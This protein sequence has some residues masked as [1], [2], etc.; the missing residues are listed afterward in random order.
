MFEPTDDAVQ[1]FGQ[2]DEVLYR[3][4]K[5][6]PTKENLSKVVKSL[7]PII[8]REVNRQAGSIPTSVLRGVGMEWAVKAVQSF[9]ESKGFKLSTHTANY[10]KK[11]R[12]SNYQMQNA[13]R[14]PEPL[15]NQYHH[16]STAVD[17]LKVELDRDPTDVELASKLG[18]KKV[19]VT[20]F[21]DRLYQDTFES[22]ALK[23][24][25]VTGFS[26]TTVLLN[27]VRDSL[28]P[29]EQIIFDNQM[30]DK[31]KQLS[32]DALAAK[33]GVNQNRL[34]YLK[35]KVIDKARS[36]KADMGDWE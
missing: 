20:G 12:R 31:G 11:M 8:N 19:E 33:L 4:W 34:Q 6:N 9:D 10:V 16:F 35:R 25:A 18:W 21:R 29:Q 27:L 5:A 23:N 17:D 22:S 36:L 28:D 26:N 15:Q 14:L 2:N 30:K 1:V 7:M 3:Q 32:N 13:A 24:H